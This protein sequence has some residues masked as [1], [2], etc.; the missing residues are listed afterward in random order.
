MAAATAPLAL[1]SAFAA[2]KPKLYSALGFAQFSVNASVIAATASQQGFV[3][4][5]LSK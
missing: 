3:V 5:E 2:S 4:A 1:R